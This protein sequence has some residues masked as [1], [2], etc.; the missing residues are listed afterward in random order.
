MSSINPKAEAR[1]RPVSV[2][3]IK[4]WEIAQAMEERLE[5]PGEVLEM[6]VSSA[7]KGENAEE[8]W[9]QLHRAA[10]KHGKVAELAQHYEQVTHDKRV[11]LL[12]P[13]QQTYIFLKAAEYFSDVHGDT[14]AAIGF[15]ERALT[16]SPANAAAFGRLEALLMNGGRMVRLA[17]LYLDAAERE[18]ETEAKLGLLR[19]SLS[20]SVTLDEA[21][22]LA[23][24]AGR[25][26]LK[27]GPDDE[28]VREDVMRRL[29]GSGR[30]ADVID[31]L[32]QALDRQPPPP[33]GEAKLHLELL[34]DLCFTVLKNP[35]RALTHLEGLLRIDPV[36]EMAL[37]SAEGL[38]EHKQL[39]PRAAAALSDAFLHAGNTE[40]AVS[41][42]TFELKHVRGP[43]RVEVQ[44]RLGILRQDSLGD[45]SG[46]LELLAP[47]VA[48][49]PGDDALRQ[50]FVNLSL[51]LSQPEQAARLLSRALSTHRDP[52]VRARVGVDVGSVYL[53]TGDVK[54]AQA[55][56]NKVLETGGDA[57][58][59]LEAARKI[60]EQ[61]AEG[62]DLKALAS[63][64]ET[65]V[66]LEPEKEARQA[67]ARR[68]AR[69][70]DEISDKPRA[71]LAFRALV[72]SPWTD[73]ALTR[74]ETAYRES[75]DDV[76]LSDVFAYRAERA[77]DRHEARDLAVKALDLRT[78]KVRDTEEAIAAYRGFAERFGPSRE[79]HGRLLPLLEQNGRFQ[80]YTETL[81]SEIGLVERDERAALYGRLG[82]I[83][84]SRLSDARGALEAFKEAIALDDDERLSRQGLDRLLAIEPTRLAAATLLEPL[85]RASGNSQELLKV[86]EA[87][88]E[89]EEL[90]SS[91]L[92]VRD[93][94]IF[95]AENELGEKDRAFE[96]AVRALRDAL[97]HEPSVAGDW[98]SVVARLAPSASNPSRR[99]ELL[100]WSLDD[101][102]IS[103]RELFD[104]AR[105]AGDLAAAA[106]DLGRAVDVYRR[107]LSFDPSSRELVQRIDELLAQLGSPEER[108][109]L[110][111]T[112]L[113]N[114]TEPSRRRELLHAL[115]RLQRL[116]LGDRNGAI[117]S[118]RTL[119]AEDPKDVSA[120]EAL[121]EVLQEAE[122]YPALGAELERG[123]GFLEGERRTRAE[124]DLADATERSG[125]A[126]GALERYRR[127][128]DEIELPDAVLSKIEELA[129]KLDDG[130]TLERVI[131]RRLSEGVPPS[132]RADLLVRQ[133]ELA[134]GARKDSDS[135]S[136]LWL[137][138][139]RLAEVAPEGRPRARELYEK[140]LGADAKRVEA[141]ERL[142]EL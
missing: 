116:E 130:A 94:A 15:A 81:L 1:R 95:L 13:E 64:L 59:L 122:D 25:R 93:E 103:S 118:L 75:G 67:A 76:G 40:R 68:L 23:I 9:A 36:H 123:L 106:G 125:N 133:A 31:V 139:A 5:D 78:A 46:A 91:R 127:L 114:E 52:G 83:R 42:L 53:R 16:A 87:R 61:F 33:P 57:P 19:R 115:S 112:A 71:L 97:D 117:K 73:E 7:A 63:V 41:M 28:N 24:Q 55:A 142:V 26:I 86:L 104:L 48:G 119:V 85:V 12:A 44:R 47:V 58:S 14:E 54:R 22:E 108:L 77:K 92:A 49:D 113:G 62:T 17:Q 37:K 126:K 80:E 39:M 29:L 3:Q 38:L 107:A 43:R 100:L 32:E 51:S 96:I 72:G 8:T 141:A 21:D 120:H 4:L 101:S 66:K 65:I 109:S 105:L 6:L 128:F 45:L 20:I 84:L 121:V 102:E 90:V 137:E 111:A 10:Q 79:L 129:T 69:L 70:A 124:L 35:E 27:L 134:F 18:P 2:L 50:R 88:A 135:A 56:F 138:A 89:G 131:E 140:A 11:K 98:I 99:A 132:R 82:H 34:V 74:L 60:A 110:Y 30:H 136:R